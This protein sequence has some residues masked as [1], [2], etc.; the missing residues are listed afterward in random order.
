MPQIL[1]MA[2]ATAAMVCMHGCHVCMQW[3][4]GKHFARFLFVAQSSQV[5]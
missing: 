3:A 4:S 2:V 1:Y 5:I